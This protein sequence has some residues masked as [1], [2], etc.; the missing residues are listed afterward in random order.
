[1]VYTVRHLYPV[2]SVSPLFISQILIGHLLCGRHYEIQQLQRSWE[3]FR[4]ELT[5]HTLLW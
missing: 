4:V 5:G 3:I 2:H 1:M